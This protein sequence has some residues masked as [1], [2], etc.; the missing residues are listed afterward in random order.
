ME[1]S[2][3][4]IVRNDR[5]GAAEFDYVTQHLSKLSL[6][7]NDKV[8][9][10]RLKT[11]VITLV[12][13]ASA[14]NSFQS[15]SGYSKLCAFLRAK[16]KKEVT[17]IAS[18]LL[19]GQD[20][21]NPGTSHKLIALMG[22][23]KLDKVIKQVSDLSKQF[24][25]DVSANPAILDNLSDDL[26]DLADK[27]M[28]VV[29]STELNQSTDPI[30]SSKLSQS[31][32]DF[33]DKILGIVDKSNPNAISSIGH[34]IFDFV[35][36]RPK[37][38][39]SLL[40][41]LLGKE[42]FSIFGKQIDLV[43]SFVDLGDSLLSLAH[44]N[45]QDL[46]KAKSKH[47]SLHE[48]KGYCLTYMS[49]SRNQEV[50]KTLPLFVNDNQNLIDPRFDDYLSSADSSAINNQDELVFSELD[51]VTNDLSGK[52][53]EKE[54]ISLKSTDIILGFV[55]TDGSLVFKSDENKAL[56]SEEPYFLEQL[57]TAGFFTSF[58]QRVSKRAFNVNGVPSNAEFLGDIARKA[59]LHELNS[60]FEFHSEDDVAVTDSDLITSFLDIKL[61]ALIESEVP[62]SVETSFWLP[63]MILK[64]LSTETNSASGE[65]QNLTKQIS[66]FLLKNDAKVDFLLL[67]CTS[68]D[69]LASRNAVIT[70]LFNKIDS[71]VIN[72]FCSTNSSLVS[73]VTSM[74][75]IGSGTALNLLTSIME[76]FMGSNR[77][78]T[79]ETKKTAIKR[80][81]FD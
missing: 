68:T 72:R 66:L 29:E 63:E 56:K 11:G 52:A 2:N 9:F 67:D 42:S 37:A 23:L 13:P 17:S 64:I 21:K 54:P 81:F 44:L 19:L 20:P 77:N 14:I 74:F 7:A 12:V 58:A 31:T 57:I 4:L 33:A 76:R 25:D 35:K 6:A 22:S 28:S 24:T 49:A 50:Y 3:N 75:T 39:A 59:I 10:F 18:E 53:D 78:T 26:K 62:I 16:T 46:A 30:E 5:L 38:A 70:D 71:S 41:Y 61:S 65:E 80:V 8:L 32:S 69:Y 51:S 36:K 45:E 60:N 1:E 47:R 27:A 73:A 34:M 48:A 40:G 15:G 43:P 79:S 55:K